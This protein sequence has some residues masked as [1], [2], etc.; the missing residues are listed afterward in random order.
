MHPRVRHDRVR[1]G[2]HQVVVEQ[3]IQ[4][5]RPRPVLDP[6]LAAEFLFDGQQ[7]G[8]EGVGGEGGGQFGGGVEEPRLLGRPADRGGVVERGQA[9][10]ANAG[11]GVQLA[12]GGHER[13]EPVAEVAAE[14]DVRGGHT[15]FRVPSSEFKVLRKQRR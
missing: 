14:G 7:R 2:P 1:P 8:Q 5:E 9:A 4:V 13:P 10:D 3:E 12:D 6:P 11:G 15:K